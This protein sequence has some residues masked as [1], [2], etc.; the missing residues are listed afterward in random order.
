MNPPRPLARPRLG[1]IVPPAEGEVP[2]DARH[3]YGDRIEFIARGLGIGGVSPDGFAPFEPGPTPLDPRTRHTAVLRRGDRLH[4]FWSRIGDAPE[5]LF[6]GVVDLAG[7]WRDWRLD[8]AREILRPPRSVAEKMYTDIR[9]WT[10]MPKGGHF[11]AMEQPQALA[12]EIV[13]FFRP[14][15]SQ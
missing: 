7:D 14:L 5:R 13:E 4:L 6:H 3:L 8:G 2:E 10:E 11:A 15:R 1:L 12:Q 9:R